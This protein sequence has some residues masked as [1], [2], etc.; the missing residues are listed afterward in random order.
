MVARPVIFFRGGKLTKFDTFLPFGKPDFGDAEVEAVSKVL[1]NG[2]VGMGPETIAFENELSQF[3]GAK[4]VVTVNSC[5]SALQ[6]SL[7]A[8]GVGVGDEVICPSLTWYSTANVVLYQRATPVFCDVDSSSFCARVEDILQCVTSRTKAVI[9]VHYGGL[10]VDVHRLRQELAEHIEIIEDSAHA[11][12]ARYDNEEV[13]GSAGNICCFSFYANKNLSTGDG[14][15]VSTDND[16]WAERIRSLRLH[17]L[18]SDAWRR[19]TSPNTLLNGQSF[20]E[21]GY[22]M[23]YTD[24]QASI[25]RIQLRRQGEF[26][27]KRRSIALVYS[28]AIADLDLGIILQKNVLEDRHAKHLFVLLLPDELGIYR[29]RLVLRMK[30]L[31]IGVSIHYV[32]L[33][34]QNVYGNSKKLQITDDIASRILTL[35]I[36]P[37]VTVVQAKEV[38]EVLGQCIRDLQAEI[39]GEAATLE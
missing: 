6:L 13:V 39:G 28:K 23:N 5:T 12:G 16:E 14:G 27:E 29:D 7:I 34:T 1:R 4:N 3:L 19:F 8:I 10:T 37:C 32:P 18:D 35:P 22:K 2:W 36:G 30:S 9:V 31:N 33:H 26:Q 17:G 11:L 21:L 15:A 20:K 24:L 38:V 25:G